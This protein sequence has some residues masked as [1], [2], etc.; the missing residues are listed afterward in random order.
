MRIR[1]KNANGLQV[2]VVTVIVYSIAITDGIAAHHHIE[3]RR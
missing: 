2:F 3:H 1:F